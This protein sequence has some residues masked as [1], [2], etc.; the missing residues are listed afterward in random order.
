MHL[1]SSK[2]QDFF[3]SI[4][5]SSTYITP[6]CCIHGKIFGEIYMIH[7]YARHTHTHTHTHT[8]PPIHTVIHTYLGLL[9]GTQWL[10]TQGTHASKCLLFLYTHY[11][12]QHMCSNNYIAERTLRS[13]TKIKFSKEGTTYDLH[14]WD[15][16]SQVHNQPTNKSR[17]DPLAQIQQPSNAQVETQWTSS[18][19]LF[20]LINETF[21]RI[22]LALLLGFGSPS[23]IFTSSCRSFGYQVC[24]WLSR[25]IYSEGKFENQL[26]N[27]EGS[28]D[29]ASDTCSLGVLSN[30]NSE[31]GVFPPSSAVL[32]G[33]H[34]M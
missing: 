31:S 13:Q 17:S 11:T 27:H 3:F 2:R 6:N 16:C 26:E 28:K 14:Q 25:A 1:L 20:L 8:P 24:M 18:P 33:P 29:N 19:A 7:W 10:R 15:R 21:F 32:Y 4:N 9:F 34:P 30:S 12:K 5:C 22:W 23:L